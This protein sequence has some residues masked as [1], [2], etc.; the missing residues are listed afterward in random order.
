[1]VIDRIAIS[2]LCQQRNHDHVGTV[3]IGY[4]T[5]NHA[6]TADVNPQIADR[7]RRAVEVIRHHG[8][9]GKTLFGDFGPAHHRRPD[10][11]HPGPVNTGNQEY[12]VVDLGQGFQV[13]GIEDVTIGVFHHHPYR[14]AQTTKL[15]AVFQ[16]IGDIRM[17]LR[18]HLLEAGTDPQ[19]A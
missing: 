1:M 5:S 13:F 3:V 8:A 4:Q 7:L 2:V 16:I 14:I 15:I 18:Q 11:L 6:R 10:G 19:V 12:F 17:A 9:A